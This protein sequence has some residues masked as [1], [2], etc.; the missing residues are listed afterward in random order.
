MPLRCLIFALRVAE[1]QHLL[2][3]PVPGRAPATNAS[4]PPVNFGDPGPHLTPPI[5]YQ[6]HSLNDIMLSYPDWQRWQSLPNN[7]T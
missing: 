4:T 6:V 5:S 7:P 2:H 1:V 3:Y